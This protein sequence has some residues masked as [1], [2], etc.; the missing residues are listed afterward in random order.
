MF[1]C[2]NTEKKII[3]KVLNVD[4]SNI[5][6]TSLSCILKSFLN[7]HITVFADIFVEGI[8]FDLNFAFFVLVA[9]EKQNL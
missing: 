2:Q 5:Q 9:K 4:I 8:V 6:I 1:Y 3:L 7:K